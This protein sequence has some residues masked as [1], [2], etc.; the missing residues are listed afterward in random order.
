MDNPPTTRW[1]AVW[2][3]FAGG[4]VAGAYI[5]K[6]PPALPRL[7]EDLGLTLVESG[8]IATM[9]N[10]MGG[11]A[12][13]FAGV[14]ADRFGQKRL[15]LAGLAVMCAGG[16]LGAASGGFASLLVARFFE[17]A[18]FILFTVAGTA[19]MAQ[20]AREPRSRAKAL[21]LWSAYM[22]SGGS[23]ALL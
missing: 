6:V 13:M 8:F 14:L 12:G 7:R 10:V 23:L 19:L 17:G 16:L 15:A 4:L 18:G 11:V 20:A 3:V 2:A 5:C 21:A 22:P 1:P 9:L